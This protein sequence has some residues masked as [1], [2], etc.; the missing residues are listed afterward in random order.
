MRVIAPETTDKFDLSGAKAHGDMLFLFTSPQSP[1]QENLVE[2]Y[3]KR[4]HEIEFDPEKDVV[5]MT[6]QILTLCMFFAAIYK[7]HKKFR[8]LLFDARSSHYV[9]HVFESSDDA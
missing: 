8:A 2:A 1:F 9:M 4:L 5:C 3:R 7:D 6:G